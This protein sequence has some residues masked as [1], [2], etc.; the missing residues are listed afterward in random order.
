M[1]IFSFIMLAGGLAFFMYGMKVMSRTLEKMAGGKLET[2]LKSMTS[3]K[4]KSMLLGAGVTVAMQSS[5]GVQ[6]MLIGLVNSG[7]MALEQTIGII[8][9]SNIGTTVTA[10]ILSMISIDTDNIFLR[11]LKPDEYSL[12]FAFIG[13]II[14]MF[15]KRE[16]YQD[17]SKVL[18]G[19]GVLMYGM[20]MMSS[21]V[22]GLS[23]SPT[24][25][26]MLT[27]FQAHPIAGVLTGAIFTAIIQSSAASVGVL[28]SL[29]LQG[30]ITF[31]VAIPIVMGQNIGTSLDS[32]LYSVGS[33]NAAKRV[34][35]VHN[36]FNIIGTT[37]WM[38]VYYLLNWIF[39]LAFLTEAINPVGIA[40]VHSI[41]NILTTILLLPFAD[42]L[43]Q[44]ATLLVPDRKTS[45]V[46]EGNEFLDA[47][48]FDTPS[49]A[50]NECINRVNDMAKLARE[51]LDAASK[52]VYD[53][54]SSMLDRIMEMEEEIDNYEDKLG[55]TL[56][57]LSSRSTSESDTQKVSIMLHVIGDLERLGDHAINLV[58]TAKEINEKEINF[59][60]TAKKELKVL[61]KAVSEILDITI[62]AF[63][64]NDVEKA[65]E[66]EPLEQVIDA[67]I[68]EI[69]ANHIARLQKGNCTIDLGFVLS[70]LL[71]NYERISDHCSNIGVA[72]IEID[73]NSFDTHKYLNDIKFG[74]SKFN[75]AFDRYS[76]RYILENY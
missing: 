13:M 19:F 48:L 53:Y 12:I 67:L 66:I 57:R 16:K 49:V 34:A 2:N 63:V 1:D 56:V 74:N 9:G 22:S 18:I 8:M 4:G 30:G 11:L 68:N 60:A 25:T 75:E 6:V 41:F 23:Q 35:V 15:S 37:V 76:E 42:K 69:K 72:M 31:G 17:V 33:N 54:D 3:S 65:M 71:T 46:I 5:T 26:S 55:T 40:A 51:T 10:W 38:L 50:I 29:A 61:D 45:V 59:S 32:L 52:V 7:I 47:R 58:K 28:Q 21:S 44:L 70:D 43:C 62:N 36:L 27:A 24:F 64:D 73:N 39:D 14:M 20:T